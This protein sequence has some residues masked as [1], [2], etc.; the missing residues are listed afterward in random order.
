MLLI[1]FGLFI[2]CIVRGRKSARGCNRQMAEVTKAMHGQVIHGKYV[3][4]L[5][6]RSSFSIDTSA[7]CS[8]PREP[9]SW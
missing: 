9:S 4:A 3:A 7:Y 1:S 6:A 8:P 5:T 2:I